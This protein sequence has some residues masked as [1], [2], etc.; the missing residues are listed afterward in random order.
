MLGW[1]ILDLDSEPELSLALRNNSMIKK[2][3]MLYISVVYINLTTVGQNRISYL[4][5][6]SFGTALSYHFSLDY[7]FGVNIS[8]PRF[9]HQILVGL[10]TTYGQTKRNLGEIGY[11]IAYKLPSRF[12]IELNTMVQLGKMPV[13]YS[14]GGPVQYRCEGSYR[15]RESIGL[16]YTK[17]GLGRKKKVQLEPFL[18]INAFQGY[19]ASQEFFPGLNIITECEKPLVAVGTRVGLRVNLGT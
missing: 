3:I 19:R 7:R 2:C 10:S 15:F 8:K 14:I 17:K 6:A 12:N 16:S 18:H 11:Q 13:A 4:A 5:E 1:S 9:N